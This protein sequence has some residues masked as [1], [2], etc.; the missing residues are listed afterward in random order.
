MRQ[1]GQ[2][3]RRLTGD[4]LH[5]G[6]SRSRV[7]G[8]LFV[9][10]V[11]AGSSNVTELE[12]IAVTNPVHDI[13]RYGIRFVASPRHADAL[14]I[15]GPLTLN[16]LTPLLSAWAVMPDHR[17]IVTAGDHADHAGLGPRPPDHQAALVA[18]LR[19]SYATVD[20]PPELRAAVVAHAAGD[21]PE[22]EAIIDALVVAMRQVQ[23][24]GATRRGRRPTGSEASSP[25]TPSSP[26]PPEAQ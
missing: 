7:R 13:G 19:E 15:T 11:D 5:A 16:M 21:P 14:L 4:G 25:P 12:L 6:P 10:H 22:P 1:Y 8:S 18:L 17:V 24:R 9:R 20:L 3:I 26:S 23:A 2:L